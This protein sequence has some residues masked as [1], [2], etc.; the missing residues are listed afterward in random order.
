MRAITQVRLQEIVRRV[1]SLFALADQLEQRLAQ[2]RG[3]AL[4]R[5]PE[6]KCSRLLLLGSA[7][8]RSFDWK[9]TLGN[10]VNLILNILGGSDLPLFLASKIP[11]LGLGGASRR[12]FNKKYPNLKE[13]N[14]SHSD[15]SDVFGD[16]YMRTV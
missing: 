10:K 11:G 6:V 15:H 13:I 12:G 14:N 5:F 3:H 4:R 7:L 8:P 2:A 16:D 9:D 1:E